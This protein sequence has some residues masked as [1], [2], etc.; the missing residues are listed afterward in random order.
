MELKTILDYFNTL[1]NDLTYVDWAFSAQ[2]SVDDEPVVIIPSPNTMKNS[3]PFTIVISVLV[4]CIG[5]GFV[6]YA[7]KEEK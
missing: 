3:F 6:I 4:I 5:I 1:F 7:K 2:Q